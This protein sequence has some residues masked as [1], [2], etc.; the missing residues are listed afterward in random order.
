MSLCVQQKFQTEVYP[1]LGDLGVQRGVMKWFLAMHTPTYNVGISPERQNKESPKKVAATPEG[2]RVDKN[3][4]TMPDLG[5]DP[6]GDVLPDLSGD[7]ETVK[8]LA[9]IMEGE[10]T[11]KDFVPPPLPKG[12]TASILKSRL[13]TKKKTKSVSPV[14]LILQ[15]SN[16]FSEAHC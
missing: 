6:Q 5:E 14:C 3:S 1:N 4:D 13:Q 16:P 15:S 8:K 10:S 2:P 11:A 12:L 9:S 7:P